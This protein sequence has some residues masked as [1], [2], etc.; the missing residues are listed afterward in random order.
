MS[1]AS[2]LD[3]E[4]TPSYTLLINVTDGVYVVGPETLE[5]NVTDVNE[6]PT[7]VNLPADVEI[8]DSL[9]SHMTLFVVDADDADDDVITYTLFSVGPFS[10]DSDGELL[11]EIPTPQANV[12]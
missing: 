4:M 1:L 12:G 8:A 6:A 3:F 11:N 9:T 10:I 7:I 5:I 2:P